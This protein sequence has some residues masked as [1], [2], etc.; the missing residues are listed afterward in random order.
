MS[1]LAG[2]SHLCIHEGVLSESR[3]KGTLIN[4]EVDKN[5][6]RS[7]PNFVDDGTGNNPSLPRCPFYQ[8]NPNEHTQSF[9][10]AKVWDIE[11]AHHL[12]KQFRP[13]L[14]IIGREEPGTVVRITYRQQLRRLL[15]LSSRHTSM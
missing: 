14:F 3:I 13:D 9:L 10:N 12:V 4:E 5:C 11:D 6:E 15:I 8:E 7:R 1:L 2:R